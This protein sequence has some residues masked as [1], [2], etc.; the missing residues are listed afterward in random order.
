MPDISS[1]EPDVVNTLTQFSDCSDSTQNV[2]AV[3]AITNG[4][5][6][7]SDEQGLFII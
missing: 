6:R 3:E 5:S 1:T 2:T 4:I 7:S